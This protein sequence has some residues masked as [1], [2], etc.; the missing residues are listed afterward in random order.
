MRFI[1]FKKFLVYWFKTVYCE[2]NTENQ[3]WN[4]FCEMPDEKELIGFSSL[5]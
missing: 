2:I 3:K 4:V 5:K 1:H